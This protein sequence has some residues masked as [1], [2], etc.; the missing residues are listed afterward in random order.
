MDWNAYIINVYCY[1]TLFI[2]I[3]ITI[4][5]PVQ[6]LSLLHLFFP[7]ST[8]GCRLGLGNSAQFFKNCNMW[9][10]FISLINKLFDLIVIA[11]LRFRFYTYRIY[12]C[13]LKQNVKRKLNFCVES[14]HIS[15]NTWKK[16]V[17]EEKKLINFH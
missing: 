7:A 11:L 1:C 14:N 16:I 5:W 9:I 17:I 2:I 6:Q 12:S 13:I 8:E 15:G 10:Q 4:W 3:F